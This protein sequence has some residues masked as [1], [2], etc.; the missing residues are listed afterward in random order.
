MFHTRALSFEIMS[1]TS[2]FGV[3]ELSYSGADVTKVSW[4]QELLCDTDDI[5]REQTGYRSHQSRVVNVLHETALI[6]TAFAYCV[7][8]EGWV[9]LF[10]RPWL[11]RSLS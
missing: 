4:C 3:R 6:P 2:W 8:G 9:P 1:H 11:G 7:K 10:S 5:G